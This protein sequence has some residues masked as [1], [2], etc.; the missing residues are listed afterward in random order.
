MTE[1]C[2][3]K[4]ITVRVSPKEAHQAEIV[5]RVEEISVNEVFRRGLEAYFEKKRADPGFVERAR[6]IIARDAELVKELS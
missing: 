3:A 1:E 6:E 2:K 4:V 5:A